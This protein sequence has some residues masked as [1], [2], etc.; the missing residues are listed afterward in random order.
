MKI[1]RQLK[2]I[3]ESKNENIRGFFN[4]SFDTLNKFDIN[5]FIILLGW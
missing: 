3:Q 4:R 2:A 1:G 5:S